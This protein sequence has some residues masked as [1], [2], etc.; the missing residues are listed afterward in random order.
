MSEEKIAEKGPGCGRWLLIGVIALMFVYLFRFE[1][2]VAWGVVSSM[3]PPLNRFQPETIPSLDQVTGIAMYVGGVIVGAV[4]FSLLIT[5]LLSQVIL[6]VHTGT[7][8]QQVFERLVSFLPGS[9]SPAIFVKEGKVVKEPEGTATGLGGGVAIVDLSSAIVLEK[10]WTPLSLG[11]GERRASGDGGGRSRPIITRPDARVGGPGTVF[12]HWGERLRGS[13]SLQK[14]FRINLGV[15]AYTSDGIEVESNVFAIFSLGQ[16]ATVI[17]VAYTGETSDDLR[18]VQIDDEKKIVSLSDELDTVDKVEIHEFAQSYISS[19]QAGVQLEPAENFT[20]Y[21]PY[22]VDEERI[23]SAIYSRGRNV[24][25]GKLDNWA[26]VPPQVATELFRNMLSQVT[27]DSLYLPDNPDRFPWQ[28]EF[29]PRLARSMRHSGVLSYQFLHRLD[30]LPIAV[31]HKIDR[32]Q[33]R[34]SEVQKLRAS[35]VLRD[36]GIKIIHVGCSELKPTNPLI[37]Q[38]RLESWRAR[39]QSEIEVARAEQDREAARALGRA[40][41][42]RQ[43][44]IIAQLSGIIKESPLSEE[45]LVL[46]IFQALEGISA[47]PTSRRMLPRDTISL[48][49]N[50]RLWLLPD[51]EVIPSMLVDGVSA[52]DKQ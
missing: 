39:W 25:D 42:E 38:Q 23:L 52:E 32:R 13:V 46:R 29:K 2:G 16:P 40:R 30:G 22:T 47:D 33:F 24:I 5:F 19:N 20:E 44:E 41:A 14:Q 6:P 36:R 18:V 35:K 9:G 3:I 51:E 28:Q 8:R 43:Q 1:L 15:R 31:G 34:I 49:R 17:K 12:I 11:G 27:Y 45:A 48:L 4:I 26:D 50:L 37:R 7:Q 21:P 10:Q